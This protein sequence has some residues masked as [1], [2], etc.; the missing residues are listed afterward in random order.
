[1]I[2]V[3]GPTASGK[4]ELAEH[5]AQELNGEI[6]SADSMQ[7]YRGMD[8]GTA[9][10][11]LSKRST[12]YHC[13]DLVAPG[14]VFNAF[15]YQK[16]ARAAFED[17]QARNKLPILCGGTG[18]YV[19]AALEDFLTETQN[20]TPLLCADKTEEPSPDICISK[21][22]ERLTAE[23]Q[24][25][26]S[27]AFHA[28]LAAVD[29]ESAALIHP[30]NVRRVVRA[31]EWLEQGSSYVE[32]SSGFDTSTEVYPVVYLGMTLPRELLYERINARVHQMIEHGLIKEVQGLLNKGYGQ[33]LTAQQAIGYKELLGVLQ[34]ESTLDLAVE[35]I[36]Q[37]TR[38]YA[39]RQHSWFK[40]NQR[41]NWL[42]GQKPLDELLEE[43]LK[44]VPQEAPP[45]KQLLQSAKRTVI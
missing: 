29:P 41:I 35:Q 4:S 39:K 33:A 37:A 25:L 30:N 21:L 17:I 42:D 8:I 14:E 19:R 20:G 1:M 18:L 10:V 38:R 16:A 11:P 5:L 36:Q 34:G 32:Q 15:L 45:S 2:A 27:E 31:F 40:R 9:K 23:A 28:K 22:R 24:E 13:V 3:V 12:T 26:G 6:V 43:A 7:V 44:I